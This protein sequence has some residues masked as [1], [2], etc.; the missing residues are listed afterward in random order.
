MAANGLEPAS[1]ARQKT[2][3]DGPVPTATVGGR[4]HVWG[5]RIGCD[6]MG[7]NANDMAPFLTLRISEV[8]ARRK[9]LLKR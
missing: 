8:V 5:R 1:E 4:G 2:S 6:E 9:T 7:V 3:A